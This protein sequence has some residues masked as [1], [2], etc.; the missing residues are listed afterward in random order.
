MQRIIR[1]GLVLA[2]T[3]PGL[4]MAASYPRGAA[5]LPTATVSLL[6]PAPG[7]EGGEEEEAEGAFHGW[8]ALR[9]I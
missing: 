4:V 9:G 7:E 3:F 2:L 1:V 6:S 5:P 8:G